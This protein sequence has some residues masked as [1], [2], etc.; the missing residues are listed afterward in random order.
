MSKYG[1]LPHNWFEGLMN[2]IGGE[3]KALAF[4]R[5]EFILTPVAKAVVKLLDLVG[6]VVVSATTE[7]FVSKKKFIVLN[8]SEALVKISYIGDN[9]TNWFLQ[10]DGKVEAPIGEQTLRYAKLCQHSVDTPIIDALGGEDKAEITLTELYGLMLKQ[11]NGEAG[12]LLNNGWANIFYIKDQLGVL[13]TVY[14]YWDG[15]GWYVNASST[16]NPYQWRDGYRV[17]SRCS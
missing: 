15:D 9:F 12:A 13:R 14:V 16:S 7:V 6:E 5:G 11:R 2:K 1:H 10:G 4:L 3:E 17:F 8:S